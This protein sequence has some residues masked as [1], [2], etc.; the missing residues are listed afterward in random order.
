MDYE[1]YL[2]HIE[3]PV[4]I[5][6]K[7]H[8]ALTMNAAF[9]VLFP[10]VKRG[11]N[12]YAFTEMYPV[13]HGL[14]SCEEGQ[15][16]VEFHQR[17]YDVHVF[18]TRYGKRARPVAR[19]ILF[20]DETQSVLLLNEVEAQSAALRASNEQIERQNILLKESIHLEA[21]ASAMR[22]RTGL[23]RDIHDTLG[24]TL[25]VIGALFSQAKAALLDSGRARRRLREALKWIH[26]SIAELEA[27]GTYDDNSFMAFLHR[28]QASMARAGLEISLDISGR[29]IPDHEYMYADLTRICQEAATNAVKHGGATRLTVNYRAGDKSISLRIKDNGR[30][31]QVINEG[32]GM[33]GMDERV[34]NLFGDLEYGFAPDGG[35]FVAVDAPVIRDEE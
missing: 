27:A 33:V 22:A 26:I 16:E 2:H 12:L 14:L 6:D 8:Q 4:V 1:G 20:T 32:F 17:H 23:L 29:E 31:E 5:L 9:E 24:H 21:E 11:E 15:Y 28:F 18:F 7:L 35:F 34:N 13:L 30:A 3:Q 19:C 10:G 25:V